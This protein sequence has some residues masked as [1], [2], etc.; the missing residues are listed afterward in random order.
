MENSAAAF[1]N[2]LAVPQNVKHRAITWP[3]NSTIRY[4][5]VL[6]A[7]TNYHTLNGI[8]QCKCVIHQYCKLEAQH[9]SQGA[10]IQ[11][12]SGL[13]SSGG[14]KGEAISLPFLPTFLGSWH[15]SFTLKTRHSRR[16]L[17][18]SYHSDLLFSLLL[19]LSGTRDYIAPAQTT[20]ENSTILGSA[21]WQP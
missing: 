10:K 16:I 4:T 9:R 12:S 3:S 20:Q 6:A 17:F 15:F 2:S 8:Q 14:S 5:P 19:P 11:G 7:V 1:A 13:P 21:D 18:I